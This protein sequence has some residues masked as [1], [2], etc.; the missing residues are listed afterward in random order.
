MARDGPV[1]ISLFEKNNMR[2]KVVSLKHKLA[3][4][5]IG[6][7]LCCMV[8][9]ENYMVTLDSMLRL[10]CMCSVAPSASRLL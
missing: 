1:F 10:K 9:L 8:A 2:V 7:S 3:V 6:W 4:F 5:C